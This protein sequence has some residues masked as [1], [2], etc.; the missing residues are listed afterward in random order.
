MR[1]AANPQGNSRDAAVVKQAPNIL[2]REVPPLPE[3][4]KSLAR[5]QRTEA[6]QLWEDLW[7]F[8]GEVY[9]PASDSY[10]IERYVS[11]LIR[12]HH[13]IDL[14][15]KEGSITEGSQGQDVAH[16]A[17]RLLISTEAMLPA[18][19]DR[20]GLSPEARLRLGLAAVESKSKLDQ[21]MEDSD[22]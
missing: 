1:P 21:F 8:G 7:R 19:E 4:L 18:L 10:V 11:L 12:R 6:T 20:L 15:N 13:L 2:A 3:G 9:K 17:A 16:P 14:L 5:N 22:N